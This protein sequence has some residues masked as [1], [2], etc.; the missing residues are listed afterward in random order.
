ML[1]K[2][3]KTPKTLILGLAGLVAFACWIGQ[4]TASE[5]PQWQPMLAK[6]FK[7]DVKDLGLK[8][9]V[10]YR[11]TG[12]VF[13]QA[14]GKV[15]CSPAGAANFKPVSETWQEVCAHAEK[16]RDAKHLF[17]LTDSGIKESTDGGATWSKPIAPPKDLAIN[18]QTW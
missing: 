9:L 1:M 6:S 16:R 7:G 11:N 4:T 5:P 17:E 18:S 8:S 3:M 13:L 12:C 15:Y 10:V 14:E 2:T